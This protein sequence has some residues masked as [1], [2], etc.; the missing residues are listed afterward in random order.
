MKKIK[1]LII[2]DERL[3]REEL[4]NLIKENDNIEIIGQASNAIEAKEAIKTHKPDLLFLDI[5]MPEM[6]GFELLNS[7]DETPNVIF[8][9]AHQDYA[10]EAFGVGA[11]DYLLKPIEKNRLF[12]AIEKIANDFNEKLDNHHQNFRKKELLGLDD[13]IFL[14]DGDKNIFISLNQVKIIESIG[15]YVRVETN[16]QKIV[17]ISSLNSLEAK[18]DPNHFFRANRKFIIN[19]NKIASI[20]Q[21]FNGGLRVEY[22]SGEF[23]EIS[24]RQAVKFKQM[25]SL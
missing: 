9:T 11:V 13:K 17:T 20:K 24:R 16:D 21:W 2:D 18:L 8:V 4:I 25:Y 7:L 6:D 3:A 5:S 15:N 22:K 23:Y 10:I 14:K 1:T 12:N 19:L